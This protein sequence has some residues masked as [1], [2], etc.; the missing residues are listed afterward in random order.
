MF[1]KLL[2]AKTAIGKKNE[3]SSVTWKHHSQIITG[4]LMALLHKYYGKK[5]FFL[6][7]PIVP[8]PQ[9]HVVYYS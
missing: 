7:L 3:I 8:S 6:R 9:H 2:A 1:R 4:L 5:T